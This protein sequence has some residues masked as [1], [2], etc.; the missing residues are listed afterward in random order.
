M[1]EARASSAE[2]GPAARLDSAACALGLPSA[3]AAVPILRNLA[4]RSHNWP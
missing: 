1:P 2:S 3:S 4:I